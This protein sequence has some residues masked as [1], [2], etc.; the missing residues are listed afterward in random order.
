MIKTWE[1]LEEKCKNCNKC[2]LAK[3]RI[4]VVIGV[5]NKNARIMFIGEGPGADE[6][7]TGIPFVG[8]AGKLMDKAFAG[9]RIKKR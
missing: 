4:N 2:D 1:E 7:K 5:G 6:D 3:T 9:V 8:K